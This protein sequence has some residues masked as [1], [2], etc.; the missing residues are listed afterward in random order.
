MLCRTVQTTLL[1]PTES[2]LT[3]LSI[4][5]P[6]ELAITFWYLPKEY[7]NIST[8]NCAALLLLVKAWMQL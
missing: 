2:F 3:K 4:L 1:Y 6:Q 5:F 8:K 7:G